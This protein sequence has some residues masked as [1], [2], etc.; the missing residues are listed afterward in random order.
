MVAA[1]RIAQ[2]DQLGPA[3]PVSTA[4]DLRHYCHSSSAACGGASVVS[5]VE[6][7]GVSTYWP[8]DVRKHG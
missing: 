1:A 7:T 4:G 6:T 5:L 2:L 3:R 8:R